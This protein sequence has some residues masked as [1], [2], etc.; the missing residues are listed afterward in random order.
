MTT[1][2][3][4]TTAQTT[5]DLYL[6]LSDPAEEALDG[7]EARLRAEAARLGWSVHRVV[8]ENDTDANGHPLPA[9]AYKRQK[10]TTATGT[11]LRTVRPRFASMLTDLHTGQANAILAEDLDRTMR[12]PRDGEDLLDAVELSGASA[13]SLSGSLTLT[14]GG[15]DSERFM[16]RILVASANKSSADTARRVALARERLA[17]QSY[18]GGRRPYGFRPDP[19]A[20]MYHK[21]LITVEAEAAVIR[22][23]AADILDRKISLKAAARELRERG[24][25]TVT[26]AP[27]TASTLRDV[28]SKKALT[29]LTDPD[30]TVVWEP[31]LERD[32]WQRL[33][34][35]FA[36]RANPGTSN[37]PRWLV[38]CYATCGVCNGPVKC[39]GTSDRRAY[40]CRDHGHVRRNAVA[41]DEYVAAHVVERLSLPDA[42][43]LLRPPPRPG[44]DTAKL[45]AEARKLRDRKRSQM[46]MHAAGTID[47]D[48]LAA[49]MKDIRARLAAVESQLAASDAPD[50]LAEFRDRPAA[51][52]WESL[53]LPRKRA[54]VRLLCTVTILP[55]ARKGAGFDPDSV[56]VEPVQP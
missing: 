48:D 3:R 23:A 1:A 29:G 25:P 56:R 2:Q 54:V 30:G 22:Q 51:A 20:P 36:S 52:V 17:G 35:L 44:T 43:D 6:R 8:V 32:Q 13:R 26:G 39:T 45:R 31:I 28:L 37:E 10:F 21:R 16:A 7:R 33:C 18:G 50:P 12:Q 42:A 34:D 55:A 40:T 5:A 4:Q 9:S 49:G 41:V 14:A 11:T 38:S 46:R 15:T 53:P 47:D 19:D 24:V 27:W